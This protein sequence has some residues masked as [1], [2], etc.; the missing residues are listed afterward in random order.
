MKV[1]PNILDFLVINCLVNSCHFLANSVLAALFVDQIDPVL[2]LIVCLSL[3]NVHFRSLETFIKVLVDSHGR[4]P[5]H[6]WLHLPD[7]W[8]RSSNLKMATYCKASIGFFLCKNVLSFTEICSM[9]FLVKA[10]D[11]KATSHAP[12][13]LPRDK[14]EGC[15][16]IDRL[17]GDKAVDDGDT[18]WGILH[19]AELLQHLVV[20]RKFV[21][22]VDT[23][24]EKSDEV[25]TFLSTLIHKLLQSVLNALSQV[26]SVA[27]VK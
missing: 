13:I 14:N 6:R 10:S 3:F 26:Q 15:G 2:S 9:A 22:V 4:S 27:E 19:I 8:D 16:S 11:D 7:H 24:W 21:H 25:C 5:C 23:I 20:K 12:G 1:E 17:D 18:E